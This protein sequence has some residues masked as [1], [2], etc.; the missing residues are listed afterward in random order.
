MPQPAGFAA[1]FPTLSL[2]QTLMLGVALGILLPALF[3]AY[4]QVTA[5]LKTEVALRV[6]APMRRVSSAQPFSSSSAQ[7]SSMDTMG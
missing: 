3:L 5:K 7:A 6:E 1:R 4:F 2:R